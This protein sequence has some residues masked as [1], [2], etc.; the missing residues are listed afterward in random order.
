MNTL[1]TCPYVCTVFYSN[2][3]V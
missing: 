3:T 1:M 2:W